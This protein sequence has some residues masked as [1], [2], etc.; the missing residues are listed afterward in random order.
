VFLKTKEEDPMTLR[1]KVVVHLALGLVVALALGAAAV[2]GQDA[3]R[4]AAA[5]TPLGTAFT[6][7]GWLT[8]AGQPVTGQ[9][10]LR[11]TLYDALSGGAQV[12]AIAQKPDVAIDEG[13]FTVQLDF[14]QTAFAGDARWLEVA[15][16]CGEGLTVLD[17]RQP[18]TPSPYALYGRAAPWSGLSGVPAG[19]ADGVDDDT[20][21]TA[22]AGLDLA[23]TTFS[24]SFA[25]TGS[26]TDVAR[27]DHNH[28]A[29]YAPADVIP[30]GAVMFFN[31]PA[32]P[33]GWSELV[34]GRG[35]AVVGL[36]AGGTLLGSVGTPLSNLENRSHNHSVNPSG[37]WDAVSG[38][39]SHNVDPPNTSTTLSGAHS[40]S[41]GAPN[42]TSDIFFSV[43][44]WTYDAARSDHTHA[45]N[46]AGE[47]A[48]NVNIGDFSSSAAGDHQH[49]VDVPDTTSTTATTS[50]VLSYIQLLVCVKN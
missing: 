18:L 20:T 4:E 13:R 8:E 47:H 25:G 21:Y 22:G 36:P 44:Q 14:G 49:W 32:C 38:Y 28:D 26:A 31:L 41:M 24:A 3:R 40:H 19:F 27:S 10:D 35:R 1:H 2:Q 23:G 5:P 46:E 16:D 9:C 48:H 45:V 12:G 29:D 33:A 7:Q 6:Y 15:V 43:T 37:F 17:P 11:F 39:H 50:N 30:A 34:Q 42:E